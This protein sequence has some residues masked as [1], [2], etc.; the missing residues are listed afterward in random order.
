MTKEIEK[1]IKSF[2][3]KDLCGYDQISVRILKLSAPYIISPLNYICNKI[4]QYGIFPERLKY[5][6]TKPIHKKGDKTLLSNYRP[7]SL[8]TSF[9]KVVEKIMYNKLVSHL[10]KTCNSKHKSVQLSGKAVNR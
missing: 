4:M 2:Q 10:K 5:S 8:L 3:I 9:S 7:I 1:I 6:I